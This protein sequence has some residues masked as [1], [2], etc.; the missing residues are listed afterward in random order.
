MDAV[1]IE[2]ALDLVADGHGVITAAAQIGV[3]RQALRHALEQSDWPTKLAHARRLGADS[4][5]EKMDGIVERVLVEDIDPHSARVALDQLRW[6]AGRW[7]PAMY[8]DRLEV[9][10]RDGGP[11]ALSVIDDAELARRVA[12][13]LSHVATGAQIEG[14][15]DSETDGPQMAHD[16]PVEAEKG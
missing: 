10:G 6:R 7:H 14:R 8:G 12:L 2:Q 5:V 1:I 3:G 4:I 9:T 16:A 13:L 11:I 15:A